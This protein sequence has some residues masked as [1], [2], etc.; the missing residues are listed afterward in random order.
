MAGRSSWRSL[1]EGLPTGRRRE[2]ERRARELDLEAGALA[3]IREALGLTQQEM[4]D[5]LQK[6]QPGIARLERQSDARLSTLR[7]YI[8]ALGGQMEIVARFPAGDVHVRQFD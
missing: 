8:R 2:I 3:E 7:D 6:A 5:R 4:A 1:Y